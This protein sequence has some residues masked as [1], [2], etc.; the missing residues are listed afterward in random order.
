[1]IAQPTAAV[2]VTAGRT[3]P[4]GPWILRAEERSNL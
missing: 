4:T 3:D 2:P 1:M